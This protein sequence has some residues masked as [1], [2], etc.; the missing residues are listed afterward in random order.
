MRTF[1]RSSSSDPVRRGSLGL[2]AALRRSLGSPRSGLVGLLFLA[3]VVIYAALFFIYP[4]VFNVSLSLRATDAVSFVT[5]ASEFVGLANYRALWREPAFLA[6]LRNTAIWTTG[7]LLFQFSLGFALALLFNRDFPGERVLRGLILVPWFLPLIV[8]A[9]AFRFFF[10]EQG[11]V[12][13]LLISSGILPRAV[14]WLTDPSL[15]IWTLTLTNIWIGIPFNFVLL[16][17]GLKE[18]PRELYEAAE[19]DGASAWQRFVH[20]VVPVMRPVIFTV[21]MLGI[22]YTVKHFD[23]VWIVTQ[24]GPANSTHLLSSLS[25]QLAFQEYD[26]GHAAAVSNAMVLLIL[27]V[28]AVFTLLSRRRGW[29]AA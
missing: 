25:Y 13:G 4:F 12:N 21:L 10:S 1:A 8:T 28:V 20:V 5:G 7:S 29:G 11:I 16:H 24:G 23:I 26:F 22:V 19:I 14:P 6:A 18:V 27:T 2:R 15:A 3:P 9:N 17:A